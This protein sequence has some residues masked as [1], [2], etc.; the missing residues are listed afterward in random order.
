MRGKSGS[1]HQKGYQDGFKICP[2]TE[3]YR[4]ECGVEASLMGLHGLEVNQSFGVLRKRVGEWANAEK[5]GFP[6]GTAALQRG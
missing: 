6:I 5:N 4:A 1:D 3:I 2:D